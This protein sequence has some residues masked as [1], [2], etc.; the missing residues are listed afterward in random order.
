MLPPHLMTLLQP[1]ESLCHYINLFLIKDNVLQSTRLSSTRTTTFRYW[2]GVSWTRAS[3]VSNWQEIHFRYT[4]LSIRKSNS[5]RRL[6]SVSGYRCFPSHARC[7]PSYIFTFH[8]ILL[9]CFTNGEQKSLHIVLRC[10]YTSLEQ[11]SQY[12]LYKMCVFKER[13]FI[14]YR[15][16]KRNSIV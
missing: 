15:G 16:G 12:N 13:Y 3:Y 9:L 11:F 7:N 14:R 2:T 1:I 6:R 5:T 8:F 10:R 4:S